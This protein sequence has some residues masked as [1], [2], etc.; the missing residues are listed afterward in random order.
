M[1]KLAN[2][3]RDRQGRDLS[4]MALAYWRGYIPRSFFSGDP[5]VIAELRAAGMSEIDAYFIADYNGV[6]KPQLLGLIRAGKKPYDA[7]SE[8][9]GG[10]YKPNVDGVSNPSWFTSS[11]YG[12]ENAKLQNAA[13]AAN[14]T[15]PVTSA[16]VVSS[17]PTQTQTVIS[18][19]VDIDLSK[20]GIPKTVYGI[21][22]IYLIAGGIGAF[23]L[24]RN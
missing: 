15:P 16:P 5:S 20:Y 14:T 9:Y 8:I 2:V 18:S 11:Q 4:K 21:P 6:S 1:A 23:L 12:A 10:V 13:Y 19:P 22:T 24:L 7:L 17:T 3:A